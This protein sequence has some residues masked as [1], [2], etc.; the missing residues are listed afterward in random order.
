MQEGGKHVIV[1]SAAQ[2]DVGLLA[3]EGKPFFRRASERVP[4]PGS[5]LAMGQ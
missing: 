3:S 2:T 1:S 4:K 5:H